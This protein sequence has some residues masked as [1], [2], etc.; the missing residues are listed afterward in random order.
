MRPFPRRAPPARPLGARAPAAWP[1]LRIHKSI[2]DQPHPSIRPAGLLRMLSQ[3]PEARRVPL[4][5]LHD[6]CAA[7]L[8]LVLL[9]DSCE[10]APPLALPAGGRSAPPDPLQQKSV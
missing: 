7:A 10:V 2:D 9:H 6:S 5:L 4:A 8:P 1:A 3:R